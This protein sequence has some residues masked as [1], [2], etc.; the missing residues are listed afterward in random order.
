MLENSGMQ[1]VAAGEREPQKGGRFDEGFPRRVFRQ[2]KCG[3]AGVGRLWQVVERSW[4]SSWDQTAK[5]TG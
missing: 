5:G 2:K 3:G 4:R 1:W